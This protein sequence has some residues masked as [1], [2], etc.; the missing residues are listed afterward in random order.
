MQLTAPARHARLV[1][2]PHQRQHRQRGL[3]RGFDNAGAAGRDGGAQLA[4][5][6]RHREVPRGDQQAGPDRLPGDQEPRTPGGRGLI[7]TVDPGGLLGEV[8]EKLSGIGDFAAR[9][10]ERFAHLERHQQRQVVDAG[11]QELE[12]GH[13]HVG[14]GAGRGG[15]EL[16]LCR[17]RC[18]QCGSGVG[19]GGIGDRAQRLSGRRVDDVEGVAPRRVDP[20][21]VDEQSLFDGVDHRLF[22]VAIH[23][24]PSIRKHSD[25]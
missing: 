14:P 1:E 15:R 23:Q 19:G 9:L 7:A 22:P 11:V 25:C 24:H 10:G 3:V 13:Q 20:F 5:A 6:H 8:S 21:A 17:D 2:D 18:V 16:A 12:R 4:G